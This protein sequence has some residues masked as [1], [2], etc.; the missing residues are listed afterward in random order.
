M[1]DL[2]TYK[3]LLTSLALP[4]VPFLLLILLGSRLILPRRGLGYLVVLLGV[5]GIWASSCQ[6]TAA[7]LLH[8]VIEP[9]AALSE[10]DRDRLAAAGH[11][12]THQQQ[13]RRGAGAV[14]S[15]VPPAAIIVLGG[16]RHTRAPEYGMSDLSAFSAE[17][18]RYGIWL[19]RQTGLPLGFSGGVG[20]GQQGAEGGGEV[21]EA[22][23]AARVAQQTFGLNLRWL[24][25]KS[26]DTRQNAA[27]TVAMLAEQR[28]PEIVLVT[29]AFHMPRARKDFEEAARRIKQAHPDW[30]GMKITPAPIDFW[31]VEEM[32]QAWIPSIAGMMNV[33]LALKE[34]LA[35]LVGA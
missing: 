22:E 1:G 21:S 8:H 26:A 15:V 32:A 34:C 24:E 17:R 5:A 33:R 31:Y 11:A 27:L 20:W 18:L 9:P 28:V 25:Q 6:S 19:A 12:F 2:G 13:L 35:K 7:W 4:P 10:A 14:A 3:P 16:G 23:T 30:G 29:N